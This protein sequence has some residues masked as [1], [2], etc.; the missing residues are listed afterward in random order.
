MVSIGADWEMP[1]TMGCEGDGK[2]YLCL[3]VIVEALEPIHVGCMS[4]AGFNG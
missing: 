1:I 4:M 2:A 3:L